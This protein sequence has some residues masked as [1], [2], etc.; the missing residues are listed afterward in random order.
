MSVGKFFGRLF[1]I[2]QQIA[3]LAGLF[4]PAFTPLVNVTMRAIVA[5][6]GKFPAAKSGSEKA[7]W[8]ADVVAVNAPDLIAAIETATG[9]QLMDEELLRDALSD[10]NNGLVKAMN[11]FRVLPKT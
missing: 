1:G 2:A 4:F 10:I 3:P 7:Q 11:A 5:A 6:E 9:K 8:A